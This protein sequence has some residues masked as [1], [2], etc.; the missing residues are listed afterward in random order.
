MNAFFCANM[1]LK[2]KNRA[3]EC[4]H[5]LFIKQKAYSLMEA[6]NTEFQLTIYNLQ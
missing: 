5:I 2:L 6:C 1:S 3:L 4:A